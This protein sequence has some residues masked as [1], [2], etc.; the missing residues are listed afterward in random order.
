MVDSHEWEWLVHELRDIQQRYEQDI[1]SG[2]C[3][4]W[5]DY[6][7]ACAARNMID[8]V[9][10]MPQVFIDEANELKAEYQLGD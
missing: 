7:A 9:C 6:S 3:D 1:A 10:G 5:A 8:T 4:D 2:G